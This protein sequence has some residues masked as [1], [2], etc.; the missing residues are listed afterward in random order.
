MFPR[1]GQSRFEHLSCSKRVR[2]V[3]ASLLRLRPSCMHAYPPPIVGYASTHISEPTADSM[4]SFSPHKQIR[5]NMDIRLADVEVCAG[6]LFHILLYVVRRIQ[7]STRC[8]FVCSFVCSTKIA[9][10]L[11]TTLSSFM[12]VFSIP[13]LHPLRAF[14]ASR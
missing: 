5:C 13:S 6:I 12:S 2:R 9:S 7:E 14:S 10:Q 3:V 11:L 1:I 4:A 8:D